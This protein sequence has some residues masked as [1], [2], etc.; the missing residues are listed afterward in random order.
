MFGFF[1]SLADAYSAVLMPDKALKPRLA[2]DASDRWGP[3]AY[4]AT[5]C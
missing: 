1:T 4:A 3:N 5:S 2:Q